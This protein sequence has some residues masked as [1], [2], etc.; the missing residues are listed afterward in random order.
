[1]F[2][3]FCMVLFLEGEVPD[4]HRGQMRKACCTCGVKERCLAQTWDK[5]MDQ[6]TGCR[7][8]ERVKRKRRSKR[9]SNNNHANKTVKVMRETQRETT[10]SNNQR[11]V[12]TTH[13]Q[14]KQLVRGSK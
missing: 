13:R 5:E 10:N 9:N 8:R 6:A 2:L 1:M 14:T 4:I 11:S 3:D 12:T 7:E